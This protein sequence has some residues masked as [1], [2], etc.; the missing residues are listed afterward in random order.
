MRSAFRKAVEDPEL[1][2]DAE[3]QRLAIDPTWG[4]EADEVIRRLYATPP[5]VIERTRK[6]V[7]VAAE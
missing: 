4:E 6:I 7:A 3:K 1:R 5:H 2:A